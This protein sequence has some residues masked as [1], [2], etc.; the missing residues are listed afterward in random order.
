MKLE[1][2]RRQLNAAIRMTFANEDELAIH[3]VAAAAYGIVRDLLGTRGRSNS[4][5]LYAADIYIS[6]PVPSRL[7]SYHR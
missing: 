6:L 3:T 4:E 1:A 5:E 2:A 7:E